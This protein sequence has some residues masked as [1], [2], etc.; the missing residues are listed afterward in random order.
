MHK[1]PSK[2]FLNECLLQWPI[3]CW[4]G[5]RWTFS[6]IK[7]MNWENEVAVWRYV[8]FGWFLVRL[9]GNQALVACQTHGW[10]SHQ[11]GWHKLFFY[12]SFLFFYH[13]PFGGNEF[14]KTHSTSSPA[15]KWSLSII[16][17]WFD[18]TNHKFVSGG[19][20]RACTPK[21][22]HLHFRLLVE[23]FL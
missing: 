7:I 22:N 4:S 18:N 17:V 12:F 10:A 5:S 11:S 19:K 6:N 2:Y 8:L 9:T 3:W 21:G 1:A 15:P 20:K 14:L 13:S 16:N 23:V